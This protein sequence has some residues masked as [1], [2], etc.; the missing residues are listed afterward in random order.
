MCETH[1]SDLF[2]LQLR[3]IKFRDL[4]TCSQK[5]ILAKPIVVI[6]C[7]Q[8]KTLSRCILMTILNSR[9][10]RSN[11]VKG[12]KNVQFYG[13]ILNLF[14][15]FHKIWHIQYTYTYSHIKVIMHY[16]N[17]TQTTQLWHQNMEWRICIKMCFLLEIYSKTL[18]LWHLGL[19]INV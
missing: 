7:S 19:K 17:N 18:Q 4:A 6:C 5:K 2:T 12:Q 11:F 15:I 3:N 16:I 14:C 9:I 8:G 13:T 1:V 10:F